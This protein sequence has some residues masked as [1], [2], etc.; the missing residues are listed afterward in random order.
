M[1][2]T[3]IQDLIQLTENRLAYLQSRRV[4]YYAIGE[5]PEVMKLDDCIAVTENTLNSLKSLLA[6]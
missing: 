2:P 6:A 5:A 3:T 4:F 1:N